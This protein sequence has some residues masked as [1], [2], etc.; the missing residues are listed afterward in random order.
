[1]EK[2]NLPNV[3]NNDK[4]KLESKNSGNF[5][6]KK[7][8]K[9]VGL[10]GLTAVTSLNAGDTIAQKIEPIITHDINDPR[11]KA[12]NDSLEAYN[13]TEGINAPNV[14]KNIFDK[15]WN[16]L[17][18]NDSSFI[19]DNDPVFNQNAPLEDG[20][21]G[22]KINISKTKKPLYDTKLHYD[23]KILTR[24]DSIVKGKLNNIKPIGY[25]NEDEYM[26]F[27][28]GP[29]FDYDKKGNY[30]K[31]RTKII[32]DKID[33]KKLKKIFPEITDEQIDERIRLERKY[34]SY[35]EKGA[36]IND[37]IVNY[38]SDESKGHMSESVVDYAQKSKHSYPVFKKPIVPYEYKPVEIAKPKVVHE[39]NNI[40]MPDGT[41]WSKEKFIE[42]YGQ[43][44]WDKK[45]GIPGGGK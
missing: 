29:A 6:S 23:D 20:Y 42:K 25:I 38:V 31:P 39:I 21:L 18:K 9:L 44:V 14:I 8:R 40:W 12:Y 1:M 15:D 27:F 33:R 7:I 32:E 17:A 30:R 28:A 37:S 24:T 3:E 22:S 45:Y 4:P 43:E 34:P 35:I 26:P 10:A 13:L 11:L 19:P 36:N 41:L 16:E 5:I 2:F